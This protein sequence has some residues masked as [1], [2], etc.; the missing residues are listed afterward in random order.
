MRML[1]RLP[2][3]CL[4]LA[5]TPATSAMAGPLLSAT[6]RGAMPLS[7]YRLT[8]GAGTLQASGWAS[9]GSAHVSLTIPTFTTTRFVTSTVPT[10]IVRQHLRGSQTIAFGPGGAVANQAL[11]ATI[12]VSL[13]IAS[14]FRLFTLPMAIGLSQ[15]PTATGFNPLIGQITVVNQFLGWTTGSFASP[16]TFSGISYG[17]Y[18]SRGS[19][20]LTAS[21]GGTLT[22]IGPSVTNVTIQGQ[23]NRH[24]PSVTRLTL[25][26]APGPG[27]GGPQPAIPEPA[28]AQLV[29]GALALLGLLRRAR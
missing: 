8:T 27:P 4:L 16:V 22:L 21:G 7:A 2:L 25:T 18:V 17:S 28:A 5:L 9:G 3:L 10:A 11:S 26:F 15:T 13:A 19:N 6:W 12:D 14:G 24:D 20:R 23:P 1:L 29:L